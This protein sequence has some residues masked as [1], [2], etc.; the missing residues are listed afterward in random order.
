LTEEYDLDN[1]TTLMIAKTAMTQRQIK[2]I[3]PSSPPGRCHET[4]RALRR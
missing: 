3:H 2:E 4:P 1:V